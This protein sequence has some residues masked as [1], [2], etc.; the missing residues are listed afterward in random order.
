MQ[1]ADEFASRVTELLEQIG[2]AEAR[3]LLTELAKGPATARMTMEA[4]ASLKRLQD[5]P[6][7]K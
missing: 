1:S 4:G 7:V 2:S 5:R 3:S 6:S